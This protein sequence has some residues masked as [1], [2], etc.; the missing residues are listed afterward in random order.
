MMSELVF[1]LIVLSLA[2][3]LGVRHADVNRVSTP[4]EWLRV[5]CEIYVLIRW[6]TLAL[7][8][9]IE[10]GVILKHKYAQDIYLSLNKVQLS[11]N[12]LKK[13][14]YYTL[15]KCLTDVSCTIDA[16]VLF[17]ALIYIT[18]RSSSFFVS[19]GS[20]TTVFAVLVYFFSICILYRYVNMM[21]DIGPYLHILLFAMKDSI[22][23]LLVFLIPLFS[24]TGMFYLATHAP[25]YSKL[26]PNSTGK[27]DRVREQFDEDYIWI[28]LTGIRL[29]IEQGAIIKFNYL[30]VYNWLMVIV[31]MVFAFVSLL[32]M[33]T[34]YT[35]KITNEYKRIHELAKRHTTYRRLAF[36]MRLH[37]KSVYSLYFLKTYLQRYNKKVVLKKDKVR[38][39][40]PAEFQN[41][42][43]KKEQESVHSKQDELRREVLERI[44]SQENK[45]DE[46]IRLIQNINK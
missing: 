44:H 17:N 13:A 42:F 14:T 1:Y 7:F 22:W 40:H 15:K 37:T 11:K 36:L 20:S 46:V 28:L 8:G 4:L 6:G 32:V 34:L 21:P 43:C 3:M 41:I 12:I 18:L 45:L 16:L 25:P 29:L 31:F 30:E 33:K 9:I 26:S 24:F 35:G 2:L 27:Y 10:F 39:E 5:I 38:S 23:F 19:V